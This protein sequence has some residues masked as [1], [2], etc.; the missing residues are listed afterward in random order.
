MKFTQIDPA[1]VDLSDDRFR[2]SYYDTGAELV[3]SIQEVGVLNPPVLTRR[4]E[5][6]ILVSGWKRVRACLELQLSCIPVFIS[7]LRD[8]LELFKN[9]VYEN[10][11]VRSLSVIEKTEI[12][13]RLKNFGTSDETLVRRFLP[14][15]NI[16]ANPDYLEIFLP[17]AQFSGDEKELIHHKNMTIMVIKALVPFPRETRAQLLPWLQALGQNKQKELLN[18]LR[19]ISLRDSRTPGEILSAPQIVKLA[20]D[21]K[22][23]PPQK[24]EKIL[25]LLR[26]ARNPGLSLWT[27]AFAAALKKIDIEKGILVNPSPFFEGEDLALHFSFRS[28]EELLSK[29][30]HVKQLAARADFNDIFKTPQDE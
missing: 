19:D 11:A 29:L 12:L 17:L 14:L 25:S 23:S 4:E 5:R 13:A 3:D 10:A 22:L 15:L 6:L 27:K 20:A 9:A 26:E 18:H 24:A 1:E 8:D 7:D 28:R 30:A 21:D 2:I 16:P